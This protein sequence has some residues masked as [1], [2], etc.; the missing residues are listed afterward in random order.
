MTKWDKRFFV[1]RDM[2][3]HWWKTKEDAS[4]PEA[5]VADGGPLCKGTISLLTNPVQLEFDS[6][7]TTKF[8]L[9]T[10]PGK[11][12]A[13]KANKYDNRV[14]S[15]DAVDSEYDREEWARVIHAH[16]EKTTKFEDLLSFLESDPKTEEA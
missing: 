3:I 6:G 16:L 13:E 1:V 8:Y 4:A 9:K 2:H 14:F 12:E 10:M 5:A 7:S 11:K 15:F